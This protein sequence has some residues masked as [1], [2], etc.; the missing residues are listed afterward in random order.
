MYLYIKYICDTVPTERDSDPVENR[1]VCVHGEDGEGVEDKSVVA[2]PR[3]VERCAGACACQPQPVCLLPVC[4]CGVCV[5]L[6]ITCARYVS[7]SSVCVF[8]SHVCARASVTSA[9]ARVSHAGCSVAVCWYEPARVMMF[10]L[11]ACSYQRHDV[12]HTHPCT[13]V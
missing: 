11:G 13:H 6:H 1:F 9:H 3:V 10:S 12:P 4:V 2:L 7:A 5:R 8:I